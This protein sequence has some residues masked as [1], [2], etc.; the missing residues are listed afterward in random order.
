[1]ELPEC[2]DLVALCAPLDPEKDTPEMRERFNAM[3]KMLLMEVVKGNI[4]KVNIGA[5]RF[6]LVEMPKIFQSS[7]IPGSKI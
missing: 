2:L 1:M 4:K 3:K 6:G 5:R 7:G